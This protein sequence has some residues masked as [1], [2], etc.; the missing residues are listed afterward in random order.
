MAELAARVD[1]IRGVLEGA[2][3]T[4]LVY[5]NSGGKDAALV[6]ILC[7]KACANTLGLIL[8]CGISRSYGVDRDDAL[9]VAGLFDIQTREIDL[10]NA[11]ESI[12][13]AVETATNL[14]D[15]AR[16]NIA[17]RLRMQTLYAIGFSENRL[18]VG[19]GNR[20]ENYLGYFT[21]WGDGDYDLNPIKDLT[22]TEV[23]EFL[24]YLNVP[25]SIINKPPSAGLYDGQTDEEDLG[26]KYSE[27]DIFLKTGEA[28]DENRAIYER[29]HAKTEHKR[30][31]PA[32]FG[33]NLT[34]GV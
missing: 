18:V 33:G 9:L 20:S 19:T 11:H 1:F 4:G 27:L 3:A 32:T 31:L 7:K 15:G 28:S 17:P 23:F 8:P 16:A 25:Q 10:A 2:G 34:K 12:V 14:T 22:V 26:I 29:Y 13:T 5:G 6:G 30:R 21:K 24:R